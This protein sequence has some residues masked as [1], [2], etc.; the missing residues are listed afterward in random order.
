MNQDLPEPKFLSVPEAAKICGVSRNTV[1]MWVKQEKLGAYKTPGR[2]NLIRPGDL[3]KFMESNGMFVPASLTELAQNDDKLMGGEL[4]GASQAP[5]T[6][7]N[8]ICTVLVVDDDPLSRSVG[9]R[10]LKDIA[11][12]YQAETGFEALHLITMHEDISIVILDLRM[13]GQHGNETVKEIKKLRNNISIIIASGF[14]GEDGANLLS[15]GDVH[16]VV[17]KPVTVQMLRDLVMEIAGPAN[18]V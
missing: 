15:S 16:A 9:A 2:T 12:V 7:A 3:V 14:A 5:E 13:P 8:A 6:S 18:A 10:A 17:Q 1:Y 11:T 4:S